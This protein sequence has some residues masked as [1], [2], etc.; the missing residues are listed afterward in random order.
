LLYCLGERRLCMLLCQ[1]CHGRLCCLLLLLHGELLLLVGE[2]LLL[3]LLLNEVLLLLLLLLL[4]LMLLLKEVLLK[5]L[6]GGCR[7]LCCGDPFLRGRG[8]RRRGPL[9]HTSDSPT[10]YLPTPRLGRLLSAVG[11]GIGLLL[12]GDVGGQQPTHRLHLL[13]GGMH[14]RRQGVIDAAR[15][16]DAACGGGLR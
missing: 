12:N 7:C 2:S 9:R 10:G 8:V 11:R 15:T 3:Q 5:V 13:E 1:F 4:M 16:N 6:G 14:T